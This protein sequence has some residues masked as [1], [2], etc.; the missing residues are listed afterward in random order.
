MGL[1][2]RFAPRND[3]KQ[4]NRLRNKSAMT[5]YGHVELVS[6]SYGLNPSPAFQAPSAQGRQGHTHR[7]ALR[8]PLSPQVARGK[9][10]SIGNMKE[11]MDYLKCPE[12]LGW[13]KAKSCK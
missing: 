10:R 1:L 12:K 2:R 7:T 3:S 8:F 13:N 6:V 9:I 11:N 4:V 5:G